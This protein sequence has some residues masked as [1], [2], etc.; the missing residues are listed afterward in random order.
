MRSP[1]KK[2]LHRVVVLSIPIGGA[3]FSF[4][5]V[6]TA[7]LVAAIFFDRLTTIMNNSIALALSTSA[8][9]NMIV[10]RRMFRK[11]RYDA[12]DLLRD[13]TTLDTEDPEI[14]RE[15]TSD[16]AE[17]ISISR[18]SVRRNAGSS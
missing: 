18:V 4:L 14:T 5:L 10:V 12:M 13:I 7:Y 8:I 2:R 9:I 3:V 17:P 15:K 11:L 6:V 1:L 16:D